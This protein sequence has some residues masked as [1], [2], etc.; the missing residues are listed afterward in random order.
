MS[1]DEEPMMNL[2]PAETASATINR[3]DCLHLS[4]LEWSAFQRMRTIIGEK[5]VFA[6]L[7]TLSQDQHRLTA[8]GFLQK[9]AEDRGR[10]ATRAAS[11]QV[12]F[13]R[14]KPV[15]LEV[16][17]YG[18]GDN[19]PLLRWFVE[20]NAAI[21]SGQIYDPEQQVDFAMSK[22]AGRA[23]SWAFGR[24]MADHGCFSTLSEFKG[25]IRAAF[26][27]PKSE[28]RTRTEF[29]EIRQ[30]K[31]DLHAYIQHV[32]YLVSSI[33]SEPIDMATQVATFMKG[34]TDG[35][36]KTYL[37]R[38]YPETL[39]Q[40][41]ALALQE[42]FSAKQARLYAFPYRA[43]HSGGSEE[44]RRQAQAAVPPLPET[45]A[46]SI[47][48]PSGAAR[49]LRPRHTSDDFFASNARR[50]KKRQPPV[51]AG[52]STGEY[53]SGVIVM[54]ETQAPS[55][56]DTRCWTT[57]TAEEPRDRL[58]QLEITVEG[59][60]T[61]LRALLDTGASNNF[62]RS[63][64]ARALA[65]VISDESRSSESKITVR[66]ATGATVTT[67]KHVTRLRVTHDGRQMEGDFIWLDL[68]DKFDVILGMPWLKKYQPIIDR[69][70][71]STSYPAMKRN[72]VNRPSARNALSVNEHDAKVCD[73]PLSTMSE[74][75]ATRKSQGQTSVAHRSVQKSDD[76]G[77]VTPM[78]TSDQGSSC[79]VISVMVTDEDGSH[80]H[81]M[82]LEDPPKDASEV[83]SSNA[84]SAVQRHPL[85]EC[86]LASS[87]V[88]DTDVLGEPTKKER[89]QA[90]G[91][92]S[93]KDSP[94]YGLLKEYEDVFPEEV[95][96]RLP[97][98][99]GPLP[100]EQVKVID[101]FF[102]ARRKAGQV[103][104]SNSPHC[105][106]TF[107]VK[108]ATG[109]W[110]IVH[111]FN[112]LNAATIPAQTP[113]PRKD[114]IIDSMQGSTIFS[115]IDLRDGFYQILMREKDIPF[116][117]CMFGVDEIPVLGCFVG[118]NRVRPDPEKIK[119]INDWPVPTSQK[120]LRKSSVLRRISINVDWKWSDECQDAFVKVKSS[121]MEA[122][123]LAIADHE[124][125]FYVV[126][127]ASDF[128]IGCALMQR[129]DADR[130][131]VICYQPRQLKPA[132]RNYPVHDK[133]LLAMKYA[134]TKFRLSFFAEYEF[135]VEYKPGRFNV[136]ADALSRRPDFESKANDSKEDRV[137][138]ITRESTPTSSLLDDV[139]RAYATDSDISRLVAHLSDPSDKSLKA[140]DPAQ[141]ARLH[142]YEMR[143]DVLYYRVDDSDEPRA[144]VPN[145]S[146]L[147]NRVLFE[148]H[149]APFRG[150]PGREKT[151]LALSRD[152]YWSH[153]YKWVRKYVCACEV[154]QRVKP[155]PVT[156]APLRSLP[157]PTD[158]W[159]SVSMDFIFG[160]PADSSK[161]TGILVIVDRFSK[162]VHLS[163]VPA[164]VTAKQTAQ[165]F[166]DSV[167]RLH[168]MPTEIV[169]DR[170]PRFTAA[171]WQELF[172]LLG[173][174][175]KMSTAD[176]PQTD[177]QTER[178]N[179]TLE[180]ILRSYAHSFTHWN[181]CLPL[182]EFAINNSVHVSIGHTPF[183]V[184]ALRHPRASSI[185]GGM[186]PPSVTSPLSGGGVRE[187]AASEQAKSAEI[188]HHHGKATA[189]A[190]I[191]DKDI[192]TTVLQ[193]QAVIRFV[194][195]SIA[196]AVD[197]QKEQ[198]DKCGRKN[199]N[200]F[201]R[202]SFVLLSTANL[203]NRVVSSD[204]NKLLP[205]YIGP[206]KVLERIG[207]AYTLE[208]PPTMRLHPTFYVGRLKAYHRHDDSLVS[209]SSG[210]RGREG[211]Q[212][213][214]CDQPRASKVVPRAARASRSSR[215]ARP[216]VGEPRSPAQRTSVDQ[217][218]ADHSEDAPRSHEQ[219]FPP[220]APP[221]RDSEG[222]QRWIVEKILA[223]RDRSSRG[224]KERVYRV[225]WLGYPPDRDTWEPAA[226]LQADVPGLVQH[227][228]SARKHHAVVTTKVLLSQLRIIAGADA[229]TPRCGL[230]STRNPKIHAFLV[231]RQQLSNGIVPEELIP[232]I[233][234]SRDTLRSVFVEIHNEG[235][236]RLRKEQRLFLSA[237]RLL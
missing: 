191:V 140:L 121:L 105:S 168:G 108:K 129:D 195:D 95:P 159:K 87:S 162:M 207:D 44:T 6:I 29:L 15:R 25:D 176:H 233:S 35:H 127:D 199:T 225:R 20:I 231:D 45:G 222:N 154:C 65:R 83:E 175:L 1:T 96:S 28:F 197:G 236:P 32:R 218:D 75:E 22:L 56:H 151:Y 211:S 124:R 26:E 160:L 8:I 18:G 10:E 232:I 183:C 230:D 59:F 68:D 126:C 37:F 39:E 11:A 130:E 82:A 80:I 187:A 146:D 128:A 62:V 132:E 30:D 12:Q 118:K 31:R 161:K 190:A 237:V 117:A 179:R 170:D 198:A 185:L 158:C 217:E 166:L 33:V 77:K 16:A 84:E 79:E 223:H 70:Q 141:R 111:A 4:D 171:F 202:N 167:F 226:M 43:A 57:T 60:T 7:A 73:G 145:D 123:V 177:G 98:D 204:S 186:S 51:D 17:K 91:W 100:R 201:Q 81:E 93:L 212:A 135:D 55:V 208:L 103:R 3:E 122:P 235:T 203:P 227:L 14:Q 234:Q 74:G 209:S 136:I 143:N 9:E 69:N 42:D 137:M 206:F 97:T 63:H 196:D 40:A 153:Q 50:I 99:K 156:N 102:E 113:I 165:I 213:Q 41:I 149:D 173:T 189:H 214:A 115:T 104:E 216:E 178:V 229:A 114:V 119:A 120:D 125:P 27:P 172:R 2:E 48:V 138:A 147:R 86:F 19:E 46:L 219:I 182:A 224:K 58:I 72:K 36:I 163:A 54:H 21:R 148:Y 110:R 90:Q 184:N 144:V 88:M 164:S 205:R 49:S 155:A 85:D 47:R 101:E 133:E 116:T 193:R 215:L 142:R 131:R 38:E 169:S 92:E 150:H 109:G 34:L 181:E 24:R 180:D 67:E 152:F 61:P 192:A 221:L 64:V 78:E 5:A 200:E 210:D 13:P 53:A 66:L 52:R 106:P 112:K 228:Q 157:V 94:F 76:E 174:Q 220:P 134:L 89:F 107:C 71:Q 194:R 23:K 139:K 188:S